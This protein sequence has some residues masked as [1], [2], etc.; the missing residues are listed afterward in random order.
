MVKLEAFYFFVY[1]LDRLILYCEI[2]CKSHQ[3]VIKCFI[4]HANRRVF[5]L[6]FGYNL[7]SLYENS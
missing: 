2:L 7:L 4:E 5:K 6:R 3:S 1:N